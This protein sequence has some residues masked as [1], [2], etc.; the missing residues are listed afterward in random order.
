M[1]PRPS[2]GARAVLRPLATSLVL[3]S[4]ASAALA[5]EHVE[6]PIPPAPPS[7]PPEEPEPESNRTV[8]R[9]RRPRD[10]AS[11][12]TV[13]ARD[14]ELRPLARPADVL[15]VAPGVHVVQHG[16]GGKANQLFLRGFDLDHGT[17]LAL[18]V[19]GV[20]V[21]A[22]SHGH[23]Q[24]YADLHWLVPELVERVE[25]AKGPYAARFGD[26]A[27]AGAI[28]VRTR[29]DLPSSRVSLT[30]GRFGTRRLVAIASPEVDEWRPLLAAEVY[31]TDGPYEHPEDLE[32]LNAFARVS[33]ELPLGSTVTLTF[34]GYGS[35][36]NASG[37]I[38]LR[39]V[40]AGRLDRF[41]SIDPL[42]GGVSSRQ[43]AAVHVRSLPTE[44]VEAEL[45]AYLA[46][47][48]LSLYSDFSFFSGDPVRGD[49]I[50]QA[51]DRRQAGI[52]ASW[53]ALRAAG[54]FELDTSMG[55]QVRSDLA[56][57]ALFHAP[58][59]ERASVSVDARV[60]E[61]SLALW[62]E[63]EVS[64]TRWLRTVAG[65]RADL[66]TFAV[67]DR[68]EDLATEGTRTSGARQASIVSPKLALVVSPGG[69]TEL[70]ADAGAG[71]HSNDARGVV[72]GEDPV[73]PLARALG[74]EVGLRTRLLDRLDLAL[75]F[76]GL[77]LESEVVWVGDE[78]TTEAR[79]P[80]SRLGAELEARLEVLPWLFADLDLSLTKAEFTEA[81][82]DAAA[83][84]L[85]PTRL[86]SGGLSARHETG[87]S[88]RLGVLHMG[89]R[90]A[91]EDSFFT[92]EGFTRLDLTLGYSAGPFELEVEATNLLDVEWRE[93]Q[94]ASV[95]RL[96]HETGPESCPAGTRPVA[97]GGA[98]LGCEDLHFTPGLPLDVR[99]NATFQF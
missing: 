76:F 13:R 62:I 26:F 38:P 97:E 22:V 11:A 36:W 92:A 4:T 82:E 49:M 43:S 74:Y 45:T 67:E 23:G 80:T 71:F 68:V 41:G 65:A 30:A 81:P 1:S 54:P 70:F 91:S 6:T 25:I 29:S 59:R 2:S 57:T 72:R 5:H 88:G 98:F 19:D 69:S 18:F 51:D 63:E 86:V 15:Q 94:F 8:V 17:D 96:P 3:V 16:G 42:E 40:R 9:A 32:R 7:D 60:R 20:P 79:G 34:T 87:L 66:F 90:A 21:N 75:A 52:D 35:G 89:D 78:G 37:Q 47:S 85:A 95:S 58:D 46:L 12:S 50:E 33:R 39:E 61:T 14:L 27:T 93:A 48:R 53:R 73:T 28:D 77:D 55:V 83:V 24:G 44:E 99:L 84:P 10:A 31:R 56:D 64:W